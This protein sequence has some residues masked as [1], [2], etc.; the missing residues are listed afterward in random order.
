MNLFSFSFLL[1]QSFADRT[2]KSLSV[3]G[4]IRFGIADFLASVHLVSK[5]LA[6][7]SF[8]F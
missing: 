2:W 6:A 8:M 5:W 3:S 4:P 1:S 7:N